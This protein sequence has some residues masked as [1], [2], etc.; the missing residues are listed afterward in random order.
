M[1]HGRAFVTVLAA[2]AAGEALAQYPSVGIDAYE[3]ISLATFNSSAGN[4]CWGYVSPTGRE[5]ALMGLNNKVAFV[6]ITNPSNPVYFASIPHSSSTWG[7]IKVYKNYAYAVTEAAGTGIQVFDL[8]DIDNHNITLVR[9]ISSPGRTHNLAVDPQAGFLYT[10]GS[11]DGTG[12]TMC[13]SLAIPSNP[14]QVGKASMTP[15]YQ[16]DGCPV[17]YTEG[18]LAGK[19]IWY[20]FSEGRGVEIHDFTDKDNP[21]QISTATYPA[22]GY[23]HQG[24]ISADR[25]FLYVDDELD[26]NNS[27]FETRSLVFDIQDPYH[28][29]FMGSFTS[30]V[31]AIDHNQYPRSGFL[32][33]ANYRSGLRI[34]DTLPNQAQP[35]Q[36]G[37]F[38]SY[39]NNNNAGFDGAWSTYPYFPSGT[40]IVSDI[41]RGLFVIDA[42]TALTRKLT[43]TK[44]TPPKGFRYYG[45]PS[46]LAESDDVRLTMSGF[47]LP[48]GARN[49]ATAIVEQTAATEDPLRMKLTLEASAPNG[50]QTVIVYAYDFL[51]GRYTFAGTVGLTQTE[52]TFTL[53]LP[54][55][56][57]RYVE[58]GTRKVLTQFAFAN[59]TPTISVSIDQFVAKTVL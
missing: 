47:M 35:V 44:F 9:T 41:N 54:G 32:F 4:D 8:T 39:P 23:C 50:N 52:Q 40:V 33:Q 3:R 30:G 24:W 51:A 43:P 20:G 26:E 1:A 48:S 37:Y 57:S 42:S 17:T 15:N 16:H 18:P 5:Y 11:R 22:I 10:C 28:P 34:F 38:D 36:V 19:T 13:F 14:V 49:T 31:N 12:T 58:P 27:G 53:D 6:E 21:V 45:L 55:K 25:K 46:D 7:D 2:L 56:G 29:V 59:P